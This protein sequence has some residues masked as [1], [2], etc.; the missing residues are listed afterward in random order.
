MPRSQVVSLLSLPIRSDS[1]LTILAEQV[2]SRHLR[3]GTFDL[4][5]DLATIDRSSL[6]V[7]LGGAEADRAFYPASV[8]KLVHL[9]AWLEALKQ[10]GRQAS[11]EEWRAVRDML[12]ESSN[13]ATALVVDQATRSTGGPE[14]DRIGL[15]NWRNARTSINRR[16]AHWGLGSLEASQKTWNEGPYGRER[17]GYGR[18][19]EARNRMSPRQATLMMVLLALGLLGR[20]EDSDE[21]M[22]FMARNLKE[23]SLQTAGFLGQSLPDGLQAW[24]KAGW[25]YAV[26]HDVAWIRN[27]AGREAVITVF[28]DRNGE[29]TEILPAIARDLAESIF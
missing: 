4:S 8:V 9:G 15:E 10:A 23:S 17:Q 18:D 25:A 22:N 13:D 11:E 7:L 16:A 26:R 24:T 5:I 27:S 28:T 29:D 3:D 14:L 1:R 21:A 2:R 12:A 19:F 20:R 6:Q